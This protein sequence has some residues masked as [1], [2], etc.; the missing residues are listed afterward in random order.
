M[1]LSLSGRH[2]LVCG[3][4][5]GIGR[6]VALELGKAGFDVGLLFRSDTQAAQSLA[7]D[8]EAL[9][10]K[11]WLFQG[12]VRNPERL[13]E[14]FDR[15]EQEGPV[16]VLV[17]SAG[18]TRDTLL[19]ASTPE[20]FEAVLGVNL[21]GT[22]NACREAARRMA[23][24]RR[25]AIVALSSVAARRPGRGQSNYAASKGA[26]ESF[27]RALAVELAPRNIRVNAVA[28]GAIDTGMTADLKAVAED[29]I[30]KRILLRRLGRPEEVAKVVAF[31]CGEAAGY[32]TGQIWNVDGGFKLE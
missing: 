17:C 30:R 8:L 5:A 1:E 15:L 22:V 6:A 4:S 9:G 18:L 23:S 25:G 26:V 21:L 16:E 12:D 31:L 24:R 27:V 20:D 14:V 19:G 28:P 3:A 10:R 11:A 29:E 7:A 32:V 13:R 2:A